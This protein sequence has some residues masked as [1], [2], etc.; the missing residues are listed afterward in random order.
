MADEDEWREKGEEYMRDEDEWREKGRNL[1]EMRM[2]VK[3]QKKKIR[4]M[5]MNGEL[6]TGGKI[7]VRLGK[8]V[9]KRRQNIKKMTF[10]RV[11]FGPTTLKNTNYLRYLIRTVCI[12]EMRMKHEQ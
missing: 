12:K 5:R 10:Y 3:G 9:I 8:M 2:K 1:R 7:Y 4:A 6:M 11:Y